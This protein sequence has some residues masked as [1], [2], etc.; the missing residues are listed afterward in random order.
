MGKSREDASTFGP[1]LVV[2]AG[3]M[4]GARNRRLV[5]TTDQVYSITS[6]Q[7]HSRSTQNI[8]AMSMAQQEALTSA[9]VHK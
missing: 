9:A 6:D 7:I 5:L 8:S 3:G 4:S 2:A 1:T